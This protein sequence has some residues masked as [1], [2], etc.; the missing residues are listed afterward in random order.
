M[1]ND[2]TQP[3]LSGR[4]ST[5]NQRPV[6]ARSQNDSVSMPAIKLQ[7]IKTREQFQELENEWDAFLLNTQTPSPFLSWDYLDVWWD[8][9]GDKGF[10]VKLYITRDSQGGV[11]G[12]Y[13]IDD[14]S[15]GRL[16]RC[17]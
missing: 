17:S 9:Y 14:F 6:T 12:C 11:D 5:L 1:K 13:P 16:C 15:K 3:L 2:M 7:Q 10:D 4:K 8:V